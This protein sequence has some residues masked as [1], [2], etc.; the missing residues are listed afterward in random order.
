MLFGLPTTPSPLLPIIGIKTVIDH[1]V[2]AY[3]GIIF[4]RI[5]LTT[6]RMNYLEPTSK[7]YILSRYNTTN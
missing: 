6:Y 3:I 1:V 4:F 5:N 7:T 2:R